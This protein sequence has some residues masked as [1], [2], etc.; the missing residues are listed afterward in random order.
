MPGLRP[1]C[2]PVTERRSRFGIGHGAWSSAKAHASSTVPSINPSGTPIDDALLSGNKWV[3]YDQLC[4]LSEEICTRCLHCDLA[5]DLLFSV[6]LMGPAPPSVSVDVRLFRESEKLK[7]EV[8]AKCRSYVT[9]DHIQQLLAAAERHP[10]SSL[11]VAELNHLLRQREV[12]VSED[13]GSEQIAGLLNVGDQ[14]LTLI[15][16]QLA[17]RGHYPCVC[18]KFLLVCTEPAFRWLPDGEL[19][20]QFEWAPLDDEAVHSAML[21]S[22]DAERRD[23]S[24][25]FNMNSGHT[26][27][28]AQHHG[29]DKPEDQT[30]EPPAIDSL[31]TVFHVLFSMVNQQ[32]QSE[33]ALEYFQTKCHMKNLK[34]ATCQGACGQRSGPGWLSA[35]CICCVLGQIPLTI[36]RTRCCDSL[37][38][39]SHCLSRSLSICSPCS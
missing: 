36:D 9:P 16:A 39:T 31:S 13:E 11:V 4:C 3:R 25:E 27:R 18:R 29:P 7:S 32:V 23:Q 1:A 33:W 38:L 15:L 34:R 21:N 24:P 10:H 6:L 12:K 19:L 8:T 30:P 2:P 22:Q 37:W 20:D 14:S 5:N 28:R 35:G 26:R 17:F